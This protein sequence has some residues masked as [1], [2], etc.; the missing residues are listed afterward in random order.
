ML[1]QLFMPLAVAFGE[2]LGLKL[3]I[4]MIAWFVSMGLHEGGHAWAAWRLGDNTAYMLGK[5]TINPFRH[6]NWNEPNS[7]ISSVVLPAITS[8]AFAQPFGQGFVCVPMGMA[9]VPVN[10][11]NFRHPSRDH[12]IVAAAGPGGDFICALG[13]FVLFFAFYPLLWQADAGALNNFTLCIIFS[14]YLTAIV[15]GVFNL[16]PIP[17]LDGSNVLYYFGN[18]RM[19]EFMDRIRPFGFMI[20]VGVFWIGGGGRLLNPIIE[21][22]LWPFFKL[23]EMVWGTRNA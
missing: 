17:P 12:A 3:V 16:V 5:R 18:W 11:N 4:G 21:A 19:R 10:P 2:G 1:S 7:V 20:I 13:A 6:V 23:P 15:Y 8:I 22:L 9:W 14:T